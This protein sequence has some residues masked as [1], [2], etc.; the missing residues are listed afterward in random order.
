MVV[1]YY[2]NE[3]KHVVHVR[4]SND[5]GVLLFFDPPQMKVLTRYRETENQDQ[6]LLNDATMCIVELRRK[7]AILVSLY[8]K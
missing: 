4:V 1:S 5:D 7:I 2:F 6:R 3:S 8:W